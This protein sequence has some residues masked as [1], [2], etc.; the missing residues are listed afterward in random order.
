MTGDESFL[1]MPDG[2]ASR[3]IHVSGSK[4]HRLAMGSYGEAGEYNGKPMFVKPGTEGPTYNL[5]YHDK[6]WR[7]R[8]L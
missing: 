4:Y 5:Y 8:S 1:A 3:T 2:K 6:S 7:V